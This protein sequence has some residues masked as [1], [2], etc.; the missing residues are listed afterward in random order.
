MQWLSAPVRYVSLAFL[1]LR[2]PA[3]E[4]FPKLSDICMLL[5]SWSSSIKYGRDSAPHPSRKMLRIG[6]TRNA[7]TVDCVGRIG[8]PRTG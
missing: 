2:E 3:R 4:V 5:G 7:L 8:I 1:P 6:L